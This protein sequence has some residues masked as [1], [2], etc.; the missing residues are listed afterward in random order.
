MT[1]RIAALR[2]PIIPAQAGIQNPARNCRSHYARDARAARGRP[3][4][5]PA[6][7]RTGYV[8]ATAGTQPG[9]GVLKYR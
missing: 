3:L 7:I 9:F 1:A 2:T 6:R 5:A 4:V 8:C